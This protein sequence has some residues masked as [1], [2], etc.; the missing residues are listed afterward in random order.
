MLAMK[1]SVDKTGMSKKLAKLGLPE[2]KS[3][4]NIDAIYMI[5]IF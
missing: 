2:S 4:K 1:I 5:E 3:N